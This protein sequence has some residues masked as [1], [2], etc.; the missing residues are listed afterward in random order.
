MFIF[1]FWLID[2]YDI[3]LIYKWLIVF[4]IF[5]YRYL[6]DIKVRLGMFYDLIDKLIKIKLSV[7]VFNSVIISKFNI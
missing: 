4:F 5:I 1:Y 6:I 3:F 7:Y 2:L